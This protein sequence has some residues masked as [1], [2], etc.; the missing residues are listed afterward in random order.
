MNIEYSKQAVKA[1]NGM[2]KRG[3]LRIKAAI[4]GLPEGDIKPLKGSK[5]SYRL[6]VGDWRILFSYPAK[7]IILIEKIAPRG[8]IYKGV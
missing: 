8:E 2:E 3:K 4:E 7:D 6:R 5:G 1:I